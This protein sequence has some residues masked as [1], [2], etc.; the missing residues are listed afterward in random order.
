MSQNRFA[1]PAMAVVALL[2]AGSLPVFLHGQGQGLLNE[3]VLSLDLALEIA[4]GAVAAG[5]ARGQ[6]VTVVIIDAS[7]NTK[8]LLRG[9]EGGPQMPDVT[10][11]KAFTALAHRGPSSEQ[12]KIWENQKNPNIGPERVALG[13]GVPIKVG[14]EVV[15]AIGVSGGGAIIEEECANAAIAKVA[16]KLK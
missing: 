9:D 8:V 11:R 7:G 10:K 6:A 14:N 1:A 4:H 3:K 5:H 13:G 15:G 2:L 16:D 12:A